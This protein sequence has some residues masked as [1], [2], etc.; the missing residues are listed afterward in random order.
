MSDT[1][2][3]IKLVLNLIDYLVIFCL[4]EILGREFKIYNRLIY[5]LHII[6]LL[7]DNLILIKQQKVRFIQ[8][9][10]EDSN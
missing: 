8:F 5:E 4:F 9:D 1:Q 2:I 6:I 3:T 7:N 10:M